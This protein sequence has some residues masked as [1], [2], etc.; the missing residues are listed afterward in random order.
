MM[1][2]TSRDGRR[3]FVQLRHVQFQ[4][5]P[6]GLVHA[7]HRQAQRGIVTKKRVMR[8]SRQLGRGKIHIKVSNYR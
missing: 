2:S 6:Q 3:Y 1:V 8:T 4:N 5:N 7:A